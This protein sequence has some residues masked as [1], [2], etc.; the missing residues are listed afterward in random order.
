MWSSKTAPLPESLSKSYLQ[1][2]SIKR[3]NEKFPYSNF[4]LNSSIDKSILRDEDSQNRND[5]LHLITT[6][7]RSGLVG[8]GAGVVELRLS[9]VS[10]FKGR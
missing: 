5:V 4:I 6:Q 9:F 2:W 1:A 3:W 8:W 10:F 7:A